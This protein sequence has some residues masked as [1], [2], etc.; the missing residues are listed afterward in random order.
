MDIDNIEINVI[1][2]ILSQILGYVRLSMTKN[3]YRYWIRNF[4]R[5]TMTRKVRL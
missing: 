5:T 2:T 4:K 1:S 3:D